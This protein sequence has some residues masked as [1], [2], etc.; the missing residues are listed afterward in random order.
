MSQRGSYM[1]K[2]LHLNQPK[3]SRK[4]EGNS[5]WK[6]MVTWQT[7]GLSCI[8]LEIKIQMCKETEATSIQFDNDDH[9]HKGEQRK[10]KDKHRDP[11]PVL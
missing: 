11:S 1:P 3:P 10:S 6:W 7:K 9:A 5:V 4:M 2:E 8:R